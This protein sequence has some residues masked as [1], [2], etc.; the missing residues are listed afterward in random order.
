M[1]SKYIEEFFQEF[2]YFNT[3]EEAIKLLKL[4]PGGKNST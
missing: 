1:V 3:I 2:G 4:K